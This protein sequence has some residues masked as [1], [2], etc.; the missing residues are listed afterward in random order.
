M[1]WYRDGHMS[2]TGKCFDIGGTTSKA[3]HLFERTH[4]PYCGPTDPRSAGNGSIMRL[5]SAPLFSAGNPQEAVERSGDS[6][7][8]THGARVC[9]DACR[10]LGGLIVGAVNGGGKD[11]L[12]SEMYCPVPGYWQDHPLAP[13]IEEVARA[14]GDDPETRRWFICGYVIA[15]LRP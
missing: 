1:R 8:T 13:E 12:L 11:E 15:R 10:Y 14:T 2:S 6:S 5:A 3:L 7:R 9:V 4:Q